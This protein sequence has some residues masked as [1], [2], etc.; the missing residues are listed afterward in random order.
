MQN[1][2]IYTIKPISKRTKCTDIAITDYQTKQN[3]DNGNY[4]TQ[5]Q[6]PINRLLVATAF[7]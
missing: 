6:L 2:L 7:D 5:Q 1:E 4:E 3:Y